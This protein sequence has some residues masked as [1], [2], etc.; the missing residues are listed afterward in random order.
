VAVIL[1]ADDDPDIRQL[2]KY[3]LTRAGHQVILAPDGRAALDV[4]FTNDVDLAILDLDMPYV[5][6]FEVCRTL[7]EH[8]RSG[9]PPVIIASGSLVPPYLEVY[10]AGATVCLPKP[11]SGAQLRAAVTDVLAEH[12]PAAT[13]AL[14]AAGPGLSRGAAAAASSPPPNRPA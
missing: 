7:R 8:P 10:A 1:S 4:L 14:A 6:G 2:I 5:D 13:S 12:G 3:V 11:F 9:Q